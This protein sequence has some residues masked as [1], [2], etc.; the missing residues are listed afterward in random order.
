MKRLLL[1]LL[2][3][4]L[5]LSA[6]CFRSSPEITVDTTPKPSPIIKDITTQEA[7]ALIEENPDLIIIDV[8]TPAEFDSGHIENAIN[9]DYYSETFQDELDNRDKD[10]TYLIYCEIGVRSADALAIMQ[11]LG[12]MEVYNMQG[13]ISQWQQDKLPTTE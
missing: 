5:I 1:V 13:G 6:G 7:S 8:R 2:V 12:F 11:Q 9:I 3:T 4:A 10:K